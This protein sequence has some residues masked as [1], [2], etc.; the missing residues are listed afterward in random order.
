MNDPPDHTERVQRRELVIARR[1]DRAEV[2]LDKLR[3]LP[4]RSV[5]VTE[6]DALR[7]EIITILVV[8][9]LRVVLAGH[10]GEILALGLGDA[11]LFVGLLDAIG[12]AVP[13]IDHAFGHGLD[14]VVD[15]LEVDVGH[16]LGEPR[17]HRLALELTVGLQAELAHPVR[18]VLD[19]ADVLDH[20]DVDALLRAH[21]ELIA[22]VPAEAVLGKIEISNRHESSRAASAIASGYEQA[23]PRGE[24]A[25]PP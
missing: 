24:F 17:C 22:V 6:Q 10:P 11:E 19:A 25:L 8:D 13:L 3:V 16:V 23:K 5:H 18:L 14:V 20:V 2:L 21:D 15:V 9:D 4:K 7:R 12:Q 1:N